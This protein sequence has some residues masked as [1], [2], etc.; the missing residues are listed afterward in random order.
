MVT[1]SYLINEILEQLPATLGSQYSVE[2]PSIIGSNNYVPDIVIKNN[3]TGAIS[4]VELKGSSMDDELPYAIVP[5]L[6]KL[7]NNTTYDDLVKKIILV[8]LSKVSTSLKQYLS[9]DDIGLVEV[10]NS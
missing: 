9:N 2:I 4:F 10:Q 7:K 1:E 6:R 8:S 3:N 5:S